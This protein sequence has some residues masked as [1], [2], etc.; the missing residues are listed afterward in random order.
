M[1]FDTA[2][3]RIKKPGKLGFTVYTDYDIA[4]IRKYIDWTFFFI[5]WGFK[6]KYPEILNDKEKGD[7]VKKLYNDANKLIDEIIKEKSLQ[8][9]AVV[10]LFPANGEGEDIIIY[11]PDNENT[12][13]A[14][15]KGLRQQRQ[16]PNSEYCYSL[17][18]FVAPVDSGVKDYIGAF[19]VTAGLNIDKKIEEYNA[20]HDEYNAILIKL[21]ADR[22]AE[23]FTELIHIRVRRELWG[24][25]PYENLSLND[26]LNIKYRGIRPAIGY[27]A[28]PEHS[29][30]DMLFDLIKAR[31]IG[32]ELTESYAM[33]P[34]AS[35]SGFIL[36]HP[37]S[38]YFGIGKIDREQVED[39]AKRKGW[40]IETAEKWLGTLLNY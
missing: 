20:K 36:A 16:A 31:E 33:I 40:S 12:E 25:A 9:N 6:G 5:S 22:L 30:K 26:L 18:D 39:Y 15:Y 3:A 8:A 23:A 29:E 4:E 32:M 34:N 27:P 17:A 24:F 10:G 37:D 7:E 35:V 38:H 13:I 19:A 28:C 14:R 1:P 11:S 21:V 2:K